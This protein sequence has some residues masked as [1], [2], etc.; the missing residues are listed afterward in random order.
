VDEAEKGALAGVLRGDNNSGRKN[1]RGKV[2]GKLD[3]TQT[4]MVSAATEALLNF[5]DENLW[6]M[7]R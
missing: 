5:R 4:L 3:M 6:R 2:G 7:S 1:I